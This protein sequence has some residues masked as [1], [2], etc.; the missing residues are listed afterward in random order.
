MPKEKFMEQE[1]IDILRQL[2]KEQSNAALTDAKKCKALLADYTKNEY[3]KESL[4]LFRAVESGVAKAIDGADDLASCKK[5]K[6]RDLEE[7]QALNPVMAA[8]IVNTLALVLRGDTTVTVSPSAEKAAVEKTSIDKPATYATPSR[9]ASSV[10]AGGMSMD[11]MYE[12]GRQYFNGIEVQ[13]DEVKAV[14]WFHK[15]AELGHA[16]AQQ[17]LGSCYLTGDGVTIDHAKCFEWF[18]KAAKQ[19]NRSA[20]FNLG[21]CYK[22]GLGVTADIAKAVEWYS[23][24]A[25]QGSKIA[26]KKLDELKSEGK[27]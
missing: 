19:G 18:S 1:F 14:E 15:A 24:A 21:L 3:K 8:D 22:S 5:A 13:K 25:S 6:I 12:K 7:E 26:Q 11:E 20:Y 23:K 10:N 2:I 17:Q 9:P 16:D 27:I 4:L